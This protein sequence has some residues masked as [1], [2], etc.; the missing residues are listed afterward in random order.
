MGKHTQ[1]RQKNEQLRDCGK[2][3]ILLL[4]RAQCAYHEPYTFPCR[5]HHD[6]PDEPCFVDSGLDKMR[7][8]QD[9]KKNGKGDCN[10]KGWVVVVERIALG[11]RNPT[12]GIGSDGGCAGVGRQIQRQ[13]KGLMSVWLDRDLGNINCDMGFI[14]FGCFCP[15]SLDIGLGCSRNRSRH[16][17]W[18]RG[19][20]HSSCR[21][22]H[23]QRQ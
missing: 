21:N 1:W 23:Y 2:S 22:K 18:R 4:P 8:H 5:A 20:K 15:S 13:T 14:I 6:E 10:A 3:I 19:S 9:T 12:I 7:D 16:R 11:C 17:S